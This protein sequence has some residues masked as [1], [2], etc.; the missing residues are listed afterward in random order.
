MRS[1]VRRERKLPGGF[2]REVFELMD[3]EV[4][5]EEEKEVVFDS[6]RSARDDGLFSE[7]EE[8]EEEEAEEGSETLGEHMVVVPISG[9]TSCVLALFLDLLYFIIGANLQI[10]HV[11]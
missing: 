9:N 6:G 3:A 10:K 8:E 5:E 1:D 2:D 4:K 7:F 11:S